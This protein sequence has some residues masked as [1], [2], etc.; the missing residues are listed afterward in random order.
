MRKRP[1]LP[2]M[3]ALPLLG[4]GN[5]T[6][7][8]DA[9]QDLNSLRTTVS[10]FAKSRLGPQASGTQL[11]VQPGA[12]DPRLRLAP[13]AA[14][15]AFLP[16]GSKPGARFTVGI[17]CAS[18]AW[19]L[20][21]P[22]TVE[23]ELPV[24]I[25]KSAAARD[26]TLTANDVELQRRRVPGFATLYLT[27]AAQLAGRHLKQSSAPGT[28]LTTDLLVEDIKVKRGQRVTLLASAGSFEVRAPG[29]AIADARPDGRVRVQNLSS[30]KI[31]EGRAESADT[32]RVGP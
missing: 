11:F 15:E 32:V 20:Y 27:D 6:A 14:P 17:R 5:A 31:V 3:I 8:V 9:T 23:S 16:P 28:A 22:V 13:C 18:P 2:L 26:T 19:S 1:V 24:L 12:L 7:Q 30:G 25:L 21:L 29:E 10:E 4:P